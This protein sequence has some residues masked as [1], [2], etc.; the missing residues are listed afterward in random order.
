MATLSKEE[1]L[2]YWLLT[3]AI[4]HTVSL[5]CFFPK[6]EWGPLNMREIPGCIATDYARE[7]LALFDHE[8]IEF[9]SSTVEDLAKTRSAVIQKLDRLL[10]FS[11]Q[12]P[13]ATLHRM[14]SRSVSDP[15]YIHRPDLKAGF[16]LTKKGG[17]A[18]EE[19]ARPNWAKFFQVFVNFDNEKPEPTSAEIASQDLDVVLAR[20]GWFREEFNDQLEFGPKIDTIDLQ[21]HDDYQVLYWKRLPAVYKATF[22]LTPIH[23]LRPIGPHG[24]PLWSQQ[25][26]W[27]MDWHWSTNEWFRQP[28]DLPD[29][30]T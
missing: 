17:E 9:D 23:P 28:W 16:R 30:T 14:L 29:W 11:E 24:E 19:V 3:A 8:W 4:D 6:Y 25:P 7:L 27:F 20:L 12:N 5:S 2:R 10:Q 21:I 22:A 13:N 1:L 18:W 15:R 26:K